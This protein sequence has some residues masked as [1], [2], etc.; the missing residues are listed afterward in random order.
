[1]VQGPN[2]AEI[3]PRVGKEAM[4][5]LLKPKRVMAVDE[6]KPRL[7]RRCRVE[8]VDPDLQDI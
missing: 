6:I 4:G 2:W 3:N 7:A 1:M 5:L 8:L